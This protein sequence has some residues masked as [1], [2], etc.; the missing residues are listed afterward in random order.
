MKGRDLGVQGGLGIRGRLLLSFLTLAIALIVALLLLIDRTARSSL[1]GELATRLESIAAAAT[2][3]IDPSLMSAAL[4]L[5]AEG[6]ERTRN[7][8]ESRRV[9]LLLQSPRRPCRWRHR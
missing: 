9:R 7:R 8:L 5:G 2:T 4:S 3:Q 1:E 6:A